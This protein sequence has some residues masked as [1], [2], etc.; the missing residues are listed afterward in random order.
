MTNFK[1]LLISI[2]ILSGHNSLA[3]DYNCFWNNS[4]EKDRGEIT[5]EILAKRMVSREAPDMRAKLSGKQAIIDNN[6]YP[7]RS[8]AQNILEGQLLYHEFYA[9]IPE[10]LSISLQVYFYFQAWTPEGSP[11]D[12]GLSFLM[13]FRQDVH[14]ASSDAPIR[15]YT[16]VATG[17]AWLDVVKSLK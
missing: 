5:Y 12:T 11:E 13:G 3:M 4:L 16:C 17:K 9:P 2:M 10:D 1:T 6:K 14:S 15:E 7:M 8:S